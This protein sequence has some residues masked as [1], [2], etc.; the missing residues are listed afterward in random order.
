MLFSKCWAHLDTNPYAWE[1]DWL[2]TSCTESN[3][4]RQ[5]AVFPKEK[6][7]SWGH[8][9]TGQQTAVLRYA[10]LSSLL[11][12]TSTDFSKAHVQQPWWITFVFAPPMT[13]V[14]IKDCRV[15]STSVLIIPYFSALCWH[16]M[17]KPETH[18]SYPHYPC[19]VQIHADIWNSLVTKSA[20]RTNAIA[21]LVRRLFLVL[22]CSRY[23]KWKSFLQ[24]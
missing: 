10:F 1:W 7:S 19:W 22:L 18:H 16:K 11:L 20:Q 4:N 8:K 5:F 15:H 2:T 13:H 12:G 3:N 17:M 6:C 24:L 9:L 14:S 23:H 21:S